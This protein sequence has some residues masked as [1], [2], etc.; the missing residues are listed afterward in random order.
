MVP[1]FVFVLCG[2]PAAFDSEALNSQ[3]GKS[4]VRNKKPTIKPIVAFLYIPAILKVKILRHDNRM[5][6]I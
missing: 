5:E 3:E 1:L 4:I 6:R 2:M